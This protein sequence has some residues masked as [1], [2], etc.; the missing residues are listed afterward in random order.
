MVFSKPTEW[1][2]R[3]KYISPAT[4]IAILEELTRRAQFGQFHNDDARTTLESPICYDVQEL[5]ETPDSRVLRGTLWWLHSLRP[6]PVISILGNET[7]VRLIGLLRRVT[8][9]PL[10]YL[11]NATQRQKLRDSGRCTSDIMRLCHRYSR[12]AGCGGR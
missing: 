12:G 10:T 3:F 2:R 8:P 11:L 1:L 9:F 5:F 4:Q 7:I 6:S